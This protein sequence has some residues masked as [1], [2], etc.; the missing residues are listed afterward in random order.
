MEDVKHHKFQLTKIS[1][2]ITDVISVYRSKDN[3]ETEVLDQLFKLIDRNKTTIICGDFNICYKS[4]RNNPLIKALEE[5]GFKQLVHQATHLG[6]GHIDQV[7]IFGLPEVKISLYSPYY[8]AKD[9]DAIL[10]EI[11]SQNLDD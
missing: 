4:E 10:I 6:G 7:Y 5:Q 1:S 9:H 11:L 2:T 3:N 8:C